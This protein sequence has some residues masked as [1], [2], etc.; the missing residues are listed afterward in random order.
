MWQVCSCFSNFLR[1]V[2]NQELRAVDELE[3]RMVPQNNPTVL[4][5][6]HS[7]PLLD[8]PAG[9]SSPLEYSSECP[10][11]HDSKYH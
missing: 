8:S 3:A 10:S 5:Q 1:S 6:Y 11:E 7:I 4:S 9:P 2:V